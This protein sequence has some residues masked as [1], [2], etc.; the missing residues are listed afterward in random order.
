MGRYITTTLTYSTATRVTSVNYSAVVNDR[1]ICTSGGI[2]ITLP[3]VSVD[4]TALK[5]GDTVQIIDAGG[6]A[7]TSSIII[8]R[9]GNNIQSLAENLTIDISNSAVTL[10]YAG[11]S[12]GW[13]LTGS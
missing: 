2:T 8:A 1:I 7:G 4:G 11:A 5:E 13:V 3:G 9:N 6:N 12:I 10:T